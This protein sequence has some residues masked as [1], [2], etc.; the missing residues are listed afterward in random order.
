MLTHHQ[1][2]KDD[3]GEELQVDE[4]GHY[5]ISHGHQ[6]SP[7]AQQILVLE[8]VVNQSVLLQ[9]QDRILHVREEIIATG[10]VVGQHHRIAEQ[11][12]A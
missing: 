3:N 6:L 1:E 8:G 7:L 12:Q 5:A 2:R 4:S 11:L 9:Q 10:V